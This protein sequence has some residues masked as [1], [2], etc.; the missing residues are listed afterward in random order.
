MAPA[1]TRD[2][3]YE[4]HPRKAAGI[5]FELDDILYSGQS[6]YQ[7]VDILQTKNYGRVML[8]DEVV[9]LTSVDEFV[10]HEMI[11]HVPLSVHP[12]PRQVLTIGGGDGGTLREVV[13]HPTVECA[14]LAEIDEKVLDV[15]REYFPEIA[16]GLDHPKSDL[17]IGDALEYIRDKRDVFDVILSDST[18]P[19]GPAVGLFEQPFYQNV[20]DALTDDGIFVAQSESPFWDGDIVRKIVKNLSPIFPVVRFYLAFI[21]TYPSGM[22]SFVFASKGLDPVKDFRS[23]ATHSFSDSLRY[24]SPEIHQAAFI[25]P[26]FVKK[27]TSV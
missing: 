19:I 12:N 10:Y 9:M 27:L 21:P 11:S 6:Q 7:K 26:P 2:F 14:V 20:Y 3:F 17:Q 1:L 24:Y 23:D 22:W 8:L 25:L 16:V 15:S 4:R 13:K 5:A 18:D